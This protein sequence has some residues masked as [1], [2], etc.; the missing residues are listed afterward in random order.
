MPV[1]AKFSLSKEMAPVSEVIIAPFKLRLST[2]NEVK[3]VPD[4]VVMLAVP[5]VRVV[6]EIEV[7]PER[8]LEDQLAVPSVIEATPVKAPEVAENVPS[9]KVPPVIVPVT[10]E[11]PKT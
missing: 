2:V 1:V 4:P 10:V 11:F 6:P 8:L 7:N 3:P 9:V 5:S